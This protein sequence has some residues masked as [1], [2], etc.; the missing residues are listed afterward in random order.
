VTP[1]S[2]SDTNEDVFRLFELHP[3]LYVVPVVQETRPLGLINRSAMIDNYARP[4]R[5]ELFGDKSCVTMMDGASIIVEH[6]TTVQDLTE[7][8][9]NSDPRI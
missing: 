1:V 6:N 5:R 3:D 4:Y 2:P 7:L 8:I 9:L